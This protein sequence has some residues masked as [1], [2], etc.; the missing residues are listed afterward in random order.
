MA[1]RNK[2]EREAVK[3]ARNAQ[4]DAMVDGAPGTSSSLGGAIGGGSLADILQQAA[5]DPEGFRQRLRAQAPGSG[6]SAFVV[7][8]DGLTPLGT[9]TRR[10][11][12]DVADTL[13]KLADLHD[14][15]ALTDDEFAAEKA[16]I[17]GES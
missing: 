3:D 16:K 14:R 2:A 9:P 6:G 13:T 12:T 11:S 15:G 8:P 17:L 4:F 1:A 7:T 10:P 5:T